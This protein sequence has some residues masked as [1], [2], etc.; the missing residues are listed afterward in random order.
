MGM[1]RWGTV[2]ALAAGAGA[3]YFLT[4]EERIGLSPEVGVPYTFLQL[5]P[6]HIEPGKC[7]ACIGGEVCMV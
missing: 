6:E 2:G 7:P 1:V 5:L 4:N 3:V